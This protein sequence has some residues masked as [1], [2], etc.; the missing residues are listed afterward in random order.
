MYV[1]PTPLAELVEHEIEE[2]EQLPVPAPVLAGGLEPATPLLPLLARD[3]DLAHLGAA[4][5][6]PERLDLRE[7]P[8]AELVAGTGEGEGDV[9]MEALEAAAAPRAADA[10][11][12]RRAA[13]AAGRRR[14]RA[15]SRSSRCASSPAA[16]L[17]ASAGSVRVAALQR[18]TPPA[19]SS[20]D[21][22]ATR[23]RQVR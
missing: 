20:R 15:A 22:A 13:V 6:R 8:L 12:E 10:V 4:S 17:A 3:L 21:T 23:C 5:L 14:R 7:D 18:S 1:W 16:R 2:L 19:A 9:R 11:L